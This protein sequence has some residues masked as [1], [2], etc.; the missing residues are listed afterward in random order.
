M[1]KKKIFTV[2]LGLPGDDFEYIPFDSDQSL[3]D[4]DIVLYKVGFGEHYANESY[5]GDLL[6]DQY[7]LHALHRICS[8]GALNSLRRPTQEKL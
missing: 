4:A 5:Q 3:L 7:R 8:T 6:F 1:A 2:G